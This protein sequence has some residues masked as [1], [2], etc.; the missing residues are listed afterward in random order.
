MKQSIERKFHRRFP[1]CK[2]IS[3]VNSLFV[4]LF[5][6]DNDHFRRKIK[7]TYN[8]SI[9]NKSYSLGLIHLPVWNQKITPSLRILNPNLTTYPA[10]MR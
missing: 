3:K 6:Y 2:T 5:I 10:N 7:V 1:I 9:W 8:M 4:L